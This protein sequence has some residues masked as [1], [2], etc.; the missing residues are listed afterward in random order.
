MMKQLHIKEQ[1]G[2]ASTN[3]N[4]AKTG[5]LSDKGSYF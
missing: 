3:M 2:V 5:L 4:L 1:L